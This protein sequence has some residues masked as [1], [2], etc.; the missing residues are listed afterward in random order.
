MLTAPRGAEKAS[1]TPP[2]APETNPKRR[3]HDQSALSTFQSLQVLRI[4][5]LDASDLRASKHYANYALRELRIPIP[6][7]SGPRSSKHYGNYALR[8]LRIRNLDTSGPRSSLHYAN[9]ALW[10]LGIEILN[11]PG[12][13]FS[14][15]F[16]N[17]TINSTKFKRIDPQSDDF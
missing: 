1:K 5:I 17:Q 9:H 12:Q 10:E 4:R 15:F 2:R 3:N 6:D 11:T 14:A 7:A 16:S 8:E 13:S